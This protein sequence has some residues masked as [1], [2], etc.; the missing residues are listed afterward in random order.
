MIDYVDSLSI[1]AEI[2][3]VFVG[4]LGIVTVLGERWAQGDWTRA[5]EVMLSTLL[6][7]SLTNLGAALLPLVLVAAT[8][9]E[10]VVWRAANG[11]LG[12]SHLVL[13]SRAAHHLKAVRS[14]AGMPRSLVVPIMIV[15]LVTHVACLLA[16]LGFAGQFVAFTLLWGLWWGLF[17]SGFQFA[18]L[19]YSAARP[20]S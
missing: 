5:E 10:E 9:N 4:L 8:S 14:H 2:S 3:A 17:V 7:V 15:G 11:A 16:A 18:A 6:L 1:I 12:I 13:W 20:T 19:L